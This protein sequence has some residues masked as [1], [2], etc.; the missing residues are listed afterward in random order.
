M[1]I[2]TV[3]RSTIGK[4]N[5]VRIGTIK[6]INLMF[7]IYCKWEIEFISFLFTE[8]LKIMVIFNLKQLGNGSYLYP[9]FVF[10]NIISKPLTV[11]VFEYFYWFEN[12]PLY[13]SIN[14]STNTHIIIF[15]MYVHTYLPSRV[16]NDA[17]VLILTQTPQILPI[18]Y[19]YWS[20][21]QSLL[22]H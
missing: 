5:D 3:N 22:I 1:P 13:G 21:H 19:C 10:E 11:D 2:L 7:N 14:I 9:C 8:T 16:N 12:F 18:P 15:Y 17:V 6:N 20:L 4:P